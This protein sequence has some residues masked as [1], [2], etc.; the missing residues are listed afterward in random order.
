MVVD[1]EPQSE[2]KDNV[3]QAGVEECVDGSEILVEDEGAS[4]DIE[5]EGV[6]QGDRGTGDQCTDICL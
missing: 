1:L 4:V 6:M 2:V 5:A 3:L